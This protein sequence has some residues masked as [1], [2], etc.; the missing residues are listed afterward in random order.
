MLLSSFESSDV[1]EKKSMF[2]SKYLRNTLIIF[3]TQLEPITMN[4]YS[5]ISFHNSLKFSF[6][7]LKWP[8]NYYC[9]AKSKICQRGTKRREVFKIQ[10][11][12][13]HVIL[14]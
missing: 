6:L 10:L 8:T 4:N 11:Q 9:Y 14:T 3:N 5:N 1:I 2:G 7:T 13:T 12:S